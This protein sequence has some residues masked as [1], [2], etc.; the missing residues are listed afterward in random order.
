MCIIALAWQVQVDFPL[1]AAANRDEF[2]ARPAAPARFWTDQPSLL[3]GRD[4]REG[5]TWLG[6]TRTGRFAALTNVREPGQPSGSRSRGLLVAEFLRGDAAP[7]A[8]LQ[9]VAASGTLYG[10]FNLLVADG[11]TLAWYSNRHVEPQRLSPGVYGVSNHLLD[12]PWPKVQRLK[13]GLAASLEAGAGAN[14]V[15]TLLSNNDQPADADL[16]DTGVGLAMERLLGPCFIRAPHYGTRCSTVVRLGAARCELVEQSY[17]EGEPGEQARFAF[18][19][20]S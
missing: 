8:Y 15:L 9:A 13:S 14:D 11:G 3:A 18:A 7:M 20:E 6:V 2:Y 12:S 10:G 4:L 1:I 19:I 17:V 16:P 5:G